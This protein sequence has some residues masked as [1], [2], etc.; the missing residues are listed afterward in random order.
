MFMPPNTLKAK[1]G[2]GGAG[3][4]LAAIKR[5]EEAVGGLKAEFQDWVGEDIARLEA[6]RGKFAQS[7]S[8]K[9]AG[10]LFRASHD[11][12]GQASTFDFPLIARVAVSL[13]KL[14]EETKTLDALPLNLIDAHV[15]AIRV[16]FR[17]KVRDVSNPT[18]IALAEELEARTV[19]TLVDQE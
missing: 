16:I 1:V 2:G 18:A 14:I 4:D 15:A 12:K 5:A 8:K 13:C 17:D 10:E 19:E 7:R 9:I 11:I 6:A 3:V